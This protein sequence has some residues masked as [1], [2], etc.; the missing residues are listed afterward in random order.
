MSD[1]SGERS[2]V[3]KPAYETPRL[4]AYGDLRNMTKA[5]GNMGG[6]DGGKSPDQKSQV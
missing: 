4:K 1:N 5:V 3:T 2:K 6:D